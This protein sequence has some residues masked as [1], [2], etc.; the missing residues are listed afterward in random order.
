[1]GG[2]FE[3]GI[4]IPVYNEEKNILA[5]LNDWQKV[6]LTLR[7]Q[8]RFFVVDDGSRDS[9]PVLLASMSSEMPALHILTQANRGHG[10]SLFEGYRMAS[11]ARWI[12]Q[13][14]ADHQ[15]ETSA[16]PLLWEK[17]DQFDLL[18]AE[19][20]PKRGTGFRN[21]ISFCSRW[22]VYIF[23]GNLLNDVNS[24]YRL[25]RNDLVKEALAIIPPGSFAPNLLL[26]SFFIAKRARI[27]STHVKRNSQT[28]QKKSLLSPQILKGSVKA[29][30]QAILFRFKI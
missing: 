14:D 20:E 17:R 3:L 1:M 25:M 9:S 7:I 22:V 5:L 11:G 8:H 18:L 28:I 10:P 15:F 4:V 19:R 6:F 23:Y 24:P 16:F 29:L 12:F 13:I 2:S 27:F 26:T 21:A 30:F